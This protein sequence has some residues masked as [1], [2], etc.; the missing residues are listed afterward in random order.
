[1]EYFKYLL[2]VVFPLKKFSFSSHLLF[3][4]V[5][6]KDEGDYE[7][8][9]EVDIVNNIVADPEVTSYYQTKNCLSLH[10]ITKLI[11]FIE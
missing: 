10:Y 6:Y 8:R 2:G 1:M 9:Y 3:G 5:V 7:V 11:V 4:E